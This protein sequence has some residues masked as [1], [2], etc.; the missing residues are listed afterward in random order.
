LYA[1]NPRDILPS[2]RLGT[3]VALELA[4]G[5]ATLSAL[6]ASAAW[7]IGEMRGRDGL[8]GGA[9]MVDVAAAEVAPRPDPAPDP[10][11]A[12]TAA[13]PSGLAADP[14]PA[15]AVVAPPAA[16]EPPVDRISS[17]FADVSDA[18]LLAPL[19]DARLTRVK[20]NFGGS[21]V[22]LRLELEGGGR[23]AFKPEQTNLQ[24]IP[25][26]E[27]AAYRID[28]LLGVGAVAPAFGR[29]FYL[30]ELLGALDPGFRG[31]LPRL[32]TEIV[33]RKNPD[34]PR[35]PIVAGEVSWWIPEID[36]ASIG[37]FRIDTTDGVVTWRRL[38]R[39]GAVI[40]PESHELLRQISAMLVFDFLIDNADRWSGSNARVSPGGKKLYFM[41]NTLSFSRDP[42]GHTKNRT[43][44]ERTQV[45]SRRMVERLRALDVERV[46]AT[47]AED[48]G[49]F[50]PLIS[51][52]ELAALMSRR[53]V[54]LAYVDGLIATHGEAAVLV[55]P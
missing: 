30:D 51:E 8:A 13:L 50:V 45:F 23:A 28:R 31:L 52:A 34:D 9:A 40:P 1:E 41:D 39:A 5:G 53:D 3:C 16:P 19:R 42:D 14:A 7:G 26:K 48:P 2:V 18:D 43:Y 12:L 47:M 35:R 29:T 38:L 55:F 22:S 36:H 25:R 17:A 33:T 49:P 6:T 46:R 44:L 27:V 32:R 24:S 15:P 54:I 10:S 21:S 37:G 20:V 11:L 4:V